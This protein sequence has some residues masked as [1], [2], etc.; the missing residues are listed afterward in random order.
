MSLHWL[1]ALG[2]NHE[3]MQRGM[4]VQVQVMTEALMESS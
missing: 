2:S 3:R 4:F 1:Q